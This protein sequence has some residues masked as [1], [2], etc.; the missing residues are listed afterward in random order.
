MVIIQ[1]VQETYLDILYGSLE[2]QIFIYL[3]DKYTQ[4]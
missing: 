1:A 2:K 3:L 4:K